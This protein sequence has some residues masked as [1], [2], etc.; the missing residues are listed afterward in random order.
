MKLLL[1]QIERFVIAVMNFLQHKATNEI[2]FDD[3]EG[4]TDY[5]DESSETSSESEFMEEGS[6]MDYIYEE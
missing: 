2:D 3:S 1:D 5:S 6:D 4:E